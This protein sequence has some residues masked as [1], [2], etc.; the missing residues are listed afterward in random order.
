MNT[1]LNSYLIF[2][3]TV[4]NENISANLS[5]SHSIISSLFAEWIPFVLRLCCV[6]CALSYRCFI[7]IMNN[8]HKIHWSLVQWTDIF[9]FVIMKIFMFTWCQPWKYNN[10]RD[11]NWF[12]YAL[13]ACNRVPFTLIG[14]CC[15][16]WF[17]EFS[18]F[19]KSTNGIL[20]LRNVHVVT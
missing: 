2:A 7:F 9:S 18:I 12:V 8:D 10:R 6:V 19:N 13:R 17:V 15:N 16:L 20:Q 5:F 14:Y 4:I 1:I 3:D 11:R